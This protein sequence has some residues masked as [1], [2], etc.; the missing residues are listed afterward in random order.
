MAQT[1]N[2]MEILFPDQTVTIGEDEITMREFSFM[3]GMRMSAV[4]A[5]LIADMAAMFDESEEASLSAI[6][7]AFSRHPDAMVAM[8]A[9]SA[10]VS[11][12]WVAGRSDRDGQTLLNAFWRVN[13]D[14]FTARLGLLQAEKMLMAMNS[15]RKPSG[16]GQGLTQESAALASENYSSD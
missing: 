14:F 10:G 16:E 7:I 9:E 6:M 2:D 3:Q 5:A 4:A 11:K 1:E 12:E 15:T 13:R 8:I